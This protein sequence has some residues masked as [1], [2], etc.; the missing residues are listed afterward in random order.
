MGISMSNKK[1]T[2]K[3]SL[4]VKEYL[5]DLNATQAAIRAGYA[6]RSAQQMGAENM[7]KPVIASAIQEAMDKRSDRL[8]LTQDKVLKDIESLRIKATDAGQFSVAARCLELLGKS[9][10]LFTDD[11]KRGT[12]IQVVVNR[13]SVPL[14]SSGG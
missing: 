1:L 12:M 9:L 5:I 10:N 13:D 3:Q 14:V 6:E 2:A 7:L 8:D 11:S 4:F